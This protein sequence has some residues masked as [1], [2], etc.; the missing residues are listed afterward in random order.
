MDYLSRKWKFSHMIARHL[1]FLVLIMM[2]GTVNAELRCK[3]FSPNMWVGLNYD[4]LIEVGEYKGNRLTPL[5]GFSRSWEG[6][7]TLSAV[8]YCNDDYGVLHKNSI[9]LFA[10]AVRNDAQK[11]EFALSFHCSENGVVNDKIVGS[12]S[13]LDERIVHPAWRVDLVNGKM[14]YL[15]GDDLEA[16]SCIAPAGVQLKIKFQLTEY[17]HP[18]LHIPRDAG[19]DYCTLVDT[20]PLLDPSAYAKGRYKIEELSKFPLVL[21]E[22]VHLAEDRQFTVEHRGCVDIYF[23]FTFKTSL[24]E[25]RREHLLAVRNILHDLEPNRDALIDTRDTKRMSLVIDEYLA[26]HKGQVGDF[27][28]CFL[29]V[30]QECIEDVSYRFI[31]RDIVIKYV[32]RP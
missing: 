18:E 3:N 8:D 16:I 2:S 25:D 6:G 27:V 29:K 28:A 30:G 5:P 22:T 13:L 7:Y 11:G 32:D 10:R 1:L 31:D 24:Q 4:K 9:I 23:E 21:L 19:E 12:V 20:K 26:T 17:Q 14:D 15:K